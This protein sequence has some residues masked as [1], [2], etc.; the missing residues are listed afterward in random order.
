M[1]RRHACLQRAAP[2][3]RA[4]SEVC[5]GRARS[6][7]RRALARTMSSDAAI[8]DDARSFCRML[9]A[10]DEQIRRLVGRMAGMQ[11]QQAGHR[12]EHARELQEAVQK[13]ARLFRRCDQLSVEYRRATDENRQLRLSLTQ[14]KTALLDAKAIIGDLQRHLAADGKGSVGP[15]Q[16]AL[17][18]VPPP[19]SRSPTPP[20]SEDEAE[21]IQASGPAV[22]TPRCSW[23]SEP[24]PR[25]VFARGIAGVG[26]DQGDGSSNTR[27]EAFVEPLAPRDL[28]KM[29]QSPA[30]WKE[31][32]GSCAARA[33]AAAAR[34]RPP[35]DERHRRLEALLLRKRLD[36]SENGGDVANDDSDGGGGGSDDD[37]ELSLQSMLRAK[38][39]RARDDGQMR[40][41][42][43]AE[44]EQ[45]MDNGVRIH[46]LL[47]SLYGPGDGGGG[48]GGGGSHAVSS[49]FELPPSPLAEASAFAGACSPAGSSPFA[50]TSPALSPPPAAATIGRPRR[51]NATSRS[52]RE[53]TLGAKLRQGDEHTFGSPRKTP[54]AAATA[55]RKAEWRERVRTTDT[56]PPRPQPPPR[57]SHGVRAAAATASHL[58]KEPSLQSK[59]RRGSP[60]DGD[61]DDASG[62]A[63]RWGEAARARSTAIDQL[64]D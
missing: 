59:M 1:T 56:S 26:G 48:G 2:S 12:L 45:M 32:D 7:Q 46:P 10:K 53:P 57:Q 25:A 49:S 3:E 42:V 35:L 30:P 27:D 62:A 20:T 63:C 34:A 64:L 38:Q 55:A 19:P 51:S 5:T 36:S 60:S 54:S 58:L 21:D 22:A 13:H 4:S 14:H 41:R 28:N 37:D 17:P 44:V 52:L 23:S 18:P 8:D 61:D 6:L 43:A 40:E 9:Q 31:R 47:H 33:A 16:P 24:R 39:R 15:P 11:Q 29:P 50:V